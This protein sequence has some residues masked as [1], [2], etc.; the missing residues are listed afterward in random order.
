MAEECKAALDT[1]H[2]GLYDRCVGAGIDPDL[3]LK[4][5]DQFAKLAPQI[6]PIVVNIINFIIGL[7][8]KKV[9]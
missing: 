7:L 9:T 5:I 2:D 4:F 3:I 8:P 6:V 1:H